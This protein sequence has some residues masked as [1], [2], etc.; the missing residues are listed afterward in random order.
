MNT[1]RLLF[2]QP[3]RLASLAPIYGALLGLLSAAFL[4]VAVFFWPGNTAPSA[5]QPDAN[6][7]MPATVSPE[8]GVTRARSARPASR[9]GRWA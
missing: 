9:G 3:P 4:R 8:P 5:S 6:Q 2:V 1:Q 7:V